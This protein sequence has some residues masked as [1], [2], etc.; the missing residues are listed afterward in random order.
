MLLLSHKNK[1]Y[2][3]K[4][5]IFKSY[6]FGPFWLWENLAIDRSKSTNKHKVQLA[7]TLGEKL[8][9]PGNTPCKTA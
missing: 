7:Q 8:M 9:I 3:K 5:S 2:I 1:K 4:L 6:L